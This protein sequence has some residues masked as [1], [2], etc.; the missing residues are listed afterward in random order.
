MES[1]EQLD[2]WNLFWGLVGFVVVCFLTSCLTFPRVGR[3]T[4]LVAAVVLLVAGVG[5]LGWGVFLV[6]KPPE[7]FHPQQ[8][9]PVVMATAAHVFGWGV[10]S[11]CGRANDLSFSVVHSP[12]VEPTC[13]RRRSILAAHAWRR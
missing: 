3:V 6:V 12:V 8:F 11:T 1:F 2:L 9:G 7:A 4:G 10:R 5:L 13:P